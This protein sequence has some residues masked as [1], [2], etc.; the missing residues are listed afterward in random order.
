MTTVPDENV[1]NIALEGVFDD[2][3][4][5][6]TLFADGDFLRVPI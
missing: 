4:N 5:V 3:Q 6:K 2:T 1:H